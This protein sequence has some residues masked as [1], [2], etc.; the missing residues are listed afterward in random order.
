MPSCSSR[1]VSHT[2]VQ[3]HTSLYILHAETAEVQQA[4]KAAVQHNLTLAVK[5]GGYSWVRFFCDLMWS[6]VTA[7]EL[8]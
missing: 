5:G 8:G 4:V 7:S 2:A 3:L 6:N 1:A